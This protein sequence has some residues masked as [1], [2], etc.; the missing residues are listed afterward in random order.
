MKC[1]IAVMK[2]QMPS[3]PLQHIGTNKYDEFCLDCF[4]FING[5]MIKTRNNK[6]NETL[7]NDTDHEVLSENLKIEAKPN[8]KIP[9][10]KCC[11]KVFL[12]SMY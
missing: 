11:L 2:N 10:I 8:E 5:P 1:V 9:T 7:A 12:A 6:I 4:N 3:S